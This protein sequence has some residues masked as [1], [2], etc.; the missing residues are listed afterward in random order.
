[1]NA[2]VIGLQ[3][4]L[5]KSATAQ[6]TPAP[7]KAQPSWVT[8]PGFVTQLL[9]FNAANAM[10]NKPVVTPRSRVTAPVT[11]GMSTIPQNVPKPIAGQSAYSSAYTANPG[12]TGAAAKSLDLSQVSQ[13]YLTGA[14][15][16]NPDE[17]LQKYVPAE[18]QEAAFA[19]REASIQ[20]Q[21]KK[22][23]E[24]YKAAIEAKNQENIRRQQALRVP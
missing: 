18:L 8:N 6:P 5:M 12:M 4:G 16:Q 3:L 10:R 23:L 11:G 9:N 1:M 17:Y 2:R 20:E 14:A 13:G 21:N 19:Q 22:R 15:M 24:E 7:A